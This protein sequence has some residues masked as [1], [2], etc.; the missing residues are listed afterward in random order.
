MDSSKTIVIWYLGRKSWNIWGI[1]EYYIRMVDFRK[2]IKMVKM[3]Q[4]EQKK[5]QEQPPSTIV[6]VTI[7]VLA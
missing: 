6:F 5:V 4:S 2:L 3:K 7:S 1:I